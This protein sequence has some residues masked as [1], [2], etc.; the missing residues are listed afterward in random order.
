MHATINSITITPN[1]LTG[2]QDVFV[3]RVRKIYEE[4]DE[5]TNEANYEF[6]SEQDMVD[7]NWS[8]ILGL[9]FKALQVKSGSGTLLDQCFFSPST[10]QPTN[11]P[12]ELK[13]PHDPQAG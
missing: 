2:R 7:A 4:I 12:T 3:R 10:Q 6:Y 8:E 5:T 13:S 9:I 11:Q 1:T